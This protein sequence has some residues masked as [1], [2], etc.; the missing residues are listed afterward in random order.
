MGQ[1]VVVQLMHQR[2][3][4]ADLAGWKALACEPVEIVA[5]QIG[6]H[7]PFVFAERHLAR[8]EEFEVVLFHCIAASSCYFSAFAFLFRAV[9]LHTN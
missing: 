1:A 8:E 7:L 6:D 5:G 3:Q 4:L 2:Q 9:L